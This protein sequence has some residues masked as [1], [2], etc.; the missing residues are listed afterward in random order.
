MVRVIY[1]CIALL[2]ATPC[3]AEEPSS[4]VVTGVSISYCHAAEIDAGRIL[5]PV[6]KVVVRRVGTCEMS[7]EYR[8]LGRQLSFRTIT[9][10]EEATQIPVSLDADIPSLTV[11]CSKVGYPVITGEFTPEETLVVARGQAVPIVSDLFAQTI[12]FTSAQTTP[13]GDTCIQLLT[14]AS[15]HQTFTFEHTFTLDTPVPLLEM[16]GTPVIEAWCERHFFRF[17]FLNLS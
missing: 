12:E 6:E 13:Q 15:T 2:L 16:N 17:R 7:V 10:T 5:C 14:F 9:L 3:L 1:F 8:W 11:H 4:D